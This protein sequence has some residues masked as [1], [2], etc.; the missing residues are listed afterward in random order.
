M[1]RAQVAKVWVY[2]GLT[3][4][5]FAF[6]NDDVAFEES[7]RFAE[8]MGLEKFLK[9]VLLFYRSAEYESLRDA[10]ARLKLNEIAKDMGHDFKRMLKE[11][12][13]VGISDI[14]RIK[15]RDFDGYDGRDLVRA[16]VAG[17]MET[18]YPVP[19]PVSNSFPIPGAQGFTHDPLC[20]SGITKFIYAVCN[21]CFFHLRTHIDFTKVG[22]DFSARF[23]HRESFVRF[24]NAFWEA[25]CL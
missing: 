8:I 18:R 4:L 6:D 12:S 7:A 2:Y 20:S 25:R 9:A 14:D 24:G 13:K 19:N 16:V 10:E 3:D 11:A 15:A 5:Y 23:S 1:D 17:Y 22:S 21:A